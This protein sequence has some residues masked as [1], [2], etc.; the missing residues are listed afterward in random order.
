MQNVKWNRGQKAQIAM[1]TTLSHPAKQAFFEDGDDSLGGL[2]HVQL[3]QDVADM[4]F[5][6]FF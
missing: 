1:I 3:V 4:G 6:V 2:G 5:D